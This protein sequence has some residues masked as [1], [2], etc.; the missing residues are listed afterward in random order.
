MP[1][2]N[3]LPPSVKRRHSENNLTTI[4]QSVKKLKMADNVAYPNMKANLGYDKDTSDEDMINDNMS[5]EDVSDWEDVSDKE[6]V[7]NKEEMSHDEDM[8]YEEDS[9]E[10]TCSESEW[11]SDS[12][13]SLSL[14]EAGSP[15]LPIAQGTTP[16]L[17][18]D[19]EY[20]HL[21]DWEPN[22]SVSQCQEEI[23][24][25]LDDEDI[26]YLARQERR[27]RYER[28]KL[29]KKLDA[30][31]KTKSLTLT[32]GRKKGDIVDW[33]K[34]D[35]V[36][37]ESAADGSRLRPKAVELILEFFKY[38]RH[39]SR[40]ECEKYCLRAYLKE[41]VGAH[42]TGE[43]LHNIHAYPSECQYPDSYMVEIIDTTVTKPALMTQ[44][45]IT[46]MTLDAYR[47]AR[48]KEEYGNFVPEYTFVG[49]MGLAP[50][51]HEL[52]VWRIVC[53]AGRPFVADADRLGLRVNQDKYVG[54]LKD[55]V[56][57]VCEPLRLAGGLNNA[58]NWP[59][60]LHNPCLDAS[61]II[62]RADW[63]G[64]AC[65]LLWGEPLVMT[66]PF[67]ASLS[68]LVCLEG[69]PTGGDEGDGSPVGPFLS[70]EGYS[71]EARELQRLWM[72]YL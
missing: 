56:D 3:T 67:G 13:M 51:H 40:A 39:L 44:F 54:I 38:H 24:Q 8:S 30:I 4:C 69:S 52:F 62:V 36:G 70:S 43:Q 9:G 26:C 50:K 22:E 35:A 19:K 25:D 16:I 10:E 18:F 68:G 49:R 31:E 57:F 34:P 6:N 20:I 14:D 2:I 5:E 48:A 41:G 63:S 58:K 46:P 28:N 23:E 1:S 71:R 33:S 15:E 72:Y 42:E 21:E 61:N 11:G 37:W 12:E 45:Y 65:V 66:L 27:V 55:Y 59:L 64:I 47:L 53:P 17:P 60:A 29:F 7:S 32:G